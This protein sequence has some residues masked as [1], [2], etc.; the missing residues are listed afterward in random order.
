MVTLK[1]RVCR[2]DFWGDSL[3]KHTS[4]R[5]RKNHSLAKIRLYR[6]DLMKWC[7]RFH[8]DA[9]YRTCHAFDVRKTGAVEASIRHE[10]A[11]WELSFMTVAAHCRQERGVR[12]HADFPSDRTF[13]PHSRQESKMAACDWRVSD[14]QLVATNGTPLV[15][16]VVPSL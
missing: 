7:G 2:S 14:I 9:T 1:Y 12:F 8:D 13:V 4:K 16:L 5:A 15:F 10:V 6:T 11:L 3:S